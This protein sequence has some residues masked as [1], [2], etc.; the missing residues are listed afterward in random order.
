MNV[1]YYFHICERGALIRDSDGIDVPDS[2]AIRSEIRNAVLSVLR[3]EHAA[4]ALAD[5]EFHIEDD[6]G[7]IVLVVPFGLA[8]TPVVV[9]G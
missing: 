1:S 5:R 3:E 8:R 9:A 2:K 4:D 6:F 7:R